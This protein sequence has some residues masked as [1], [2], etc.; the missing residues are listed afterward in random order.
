MLAGPH[1]RVVNADIWNIRQYDLHGRHAIWRPVHTRWGFWVLWFM[2]PCLQTGDW[3][4]K[5]YLRLFWPRRG[6]QSHTVHP[7]TSPVAVLAD[8]II[9]KIPASIVIHFSADDVQKRW[10]VWRAGDR[11]LRDGAGDWC[12]GR[13]RH[14]SQPSATGG[15][16]R[17]GDAAYATR[18]IKPYYGW[19]NAYRQTCA[20]IR[21]RRPN[22]AGRSS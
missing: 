4:A 17:S 3:F 5:R 1:D 11:R 10:T 16:N 7:R 6:L 12:T 8:N 13:L 2:P 20:K 22:L 18:V 19:P 21:P 9:E 14:Q 15:Q